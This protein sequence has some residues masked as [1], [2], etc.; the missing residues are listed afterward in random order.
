MTYDMAVVN[1]AYATA[2]SMGAS[3]KVMLALFEAAIVESG[4]RNLNYGNDDSVGFLQQRPSQGW[5]NPMDVPSATRSFVS[6]ASPIQNSHATA[7]QLAQA[8]QRSAFPLKYDAVKTQASS[9]LAQVAGSNPQVTQL[10]MGFGG[11]FENITKI[12]DTLSDPGMWKRIGLF[13]GGLIL[14]GLAVMAVTGTGSLV[15]PLS[16]A[17]SALSIVKSVKGGG[18]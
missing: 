16:R 14:F 10:G 6:K 2:K 12:I 7:G 18:E 3:D 4:F 17:K 1:T 5:P 15:N 9:L 11:G 13:V 8:V